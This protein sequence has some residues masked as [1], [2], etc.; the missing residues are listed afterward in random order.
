[1]Q[2]SLFCVA[3]L[4]FIVLA[5]ST[6]LSA[7]PGL[8]LFEQKIRPLLSSRCQGCHNDALRFSNLSFDT[9]LGF[10]AGGAHGARGGHDRDRRDGTVGRLAHAAESPGDRGLVRALT[11][12]IRER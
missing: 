9:G 4:V 6:R 11:R 1:M 7:D 5:G 10:R 12:V 8:E 2:T 3:P